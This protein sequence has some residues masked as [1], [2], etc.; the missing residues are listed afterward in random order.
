MIYKVT[1]SSDL[2]REEVEKMVVV[3]VCS[4]LIKAENFQSQILYLRFP[5]DYK[6]FKGVR[7][8]TKAI[9]ELAG[10]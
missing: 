1:T 3:S 7:D 2:E 4:S 9:K 10:K 5:D 6:D 8:L